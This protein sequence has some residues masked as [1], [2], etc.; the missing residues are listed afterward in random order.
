MVENKT[1]GDQGND[2]PKYEIGAQPALHGIAKKRY[3]TGQENT[4]SIKTLIFI[5][6]TGQH[7]SPQPELRAK[8]ALIFFFHEW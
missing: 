2:H 8:H 5:E 7:E 4:S 3:K 6:N 1:C